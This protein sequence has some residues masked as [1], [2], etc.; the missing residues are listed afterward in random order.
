MSS[1]NQVLE[2][3]TKLAGSYNAQLSAYGNVKSTL[4]GFQ[5]ALTPL[6]PDTFGV[7]KAV[8]A[9]SGNGTLSTDPF[10]AEVSPPDPK[11]IKAQKLQS[12]GIDANLATFNSG[13]SLAIKV[14]KNP[15]FFISLDGNSSLSELSDQINAAKGDVSARVTTDEQGSH[16]VLES[17]VGGTANAM[18]VTGTGSLSQF[19]YDPSDSAPA[20]MTEIQAPEDV[21]AAVNGS[22]SVSVTALAQAAKLKSAALDNAITFNNGMLAIKMGNGSTTVINPTS[23]TLSGIRDA[24]NSS[25][26]GINA[27]IVNDGK[28]SHLVLTA[29]DSG[30]ANAI[31]VTGTQDFGVLSTGAW[32]DERTNP[33]TQTPSTMVTVQAAQDAAVEVE[34]VAIT[35]ATNKV[36]NAI[37]GLTL[38][39]TKVTTKDDKY[40]LSI[41]N[42]ATGVQATATKFVDAYNTLAKALGTMT[43]YDAAT[44]TSGPLQRDSTVKGIQRQLS[45]TLIEAVGTAGK[46]QTLNDVGISLQ[47]DGTLALDAAK[48]TKATTDQFSDVKKLFTSPEGVITRLNSLL[49]DMLSEGGVV[50]SRTKGLQTSLK[51]N[52][53]RQTQV[54]TRLDGIQ[55]RYTKQFNALDVTLT[56]L[57]GKQSALTSQLSALTANQR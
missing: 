18:R 32:N 31:T 21:A 20:G 3:L 25:N 53:D 40:N 23:N 41:A 7:Q 38:N 50:E 5:T 34:G 26:I 17:T 29:K 8:I 43:A 45:N 36:T 6:T 28:T 48:L 19:S 47:K 24:I 16:L 37:P 33:P 56:K 10:T 27:T 46:L 39:L 57:Q 13:D 30:T 4:S 35:S 55:A 12:D 22:Y 9:N 54:Q 2:P 1:E 14:G 11:S 52:T 44:K 15:P 42:D 51:L 49:T